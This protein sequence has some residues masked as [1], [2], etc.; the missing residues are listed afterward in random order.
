MELTEPA[1]PGRFV[2][3]DTREGWVSAWAH[4]ID[5]ATEPGAHHVVLDVSGLRPYAA[6][7]KRFGGKASGPAPF[8]AA[9]LA[10]ADVVSGAV[11]RRLSGLE[12]MLA[13]HEIAAAVVAGGTRRSARLALMHW[14][15]QE[16]FDF[17]SCKADHMSHWSAN[18]SV[19]IDA[20]FRSALRSGDEHAKAVFGAVTTGMA[21]NGEPGF[22]DTA[23]A[24][25][26][27]PKPLRSVNPCLAGG[28]RLLTRDG[29]VPIRDLAGK[30]FE[31]WNGQEWAQSKAWSTG[32]KPVYEAR[33]T[34]GASIKATADHILAT[35]DG[36]APVAEL[37]GR[38]AVVMRAPGDNEDSS[39]RV[40]SVAYVG[41]EEVFDFS[42]PLTHWGWANG[43]KV[44]NSGEAFLA[45]DNGNDGA[46][47]SCNLGQVDLDAFG[48]DMEGAIE[49]VELMARFLYRSTLNPHP[50]EPARR[51]EAV[52]RR[53][54]VGVM[55]VQGWAAAHG[56]KLSELPDSQE[57]LGK[58]TE[59]RLAARRSADT[60][61]D[62]LGTPRPVKVTAVAPTGTI[63]NL[64][65]T[66]PGPH[67]VFARYFLRRVR[68]TEH[69]AA[70]RRLAGEGYDVVDDIYA[71]A[72]KVVAFPMRDSVLDRHP[73]ELIEQADEIPV[74][75]FLDI[76]VA[77]QET[78]CGGTDGQAVSATAQVPAGTSPDDL[79]R[80]IASRLG[81]LK[82]I[83]VFPDVSRPLPPLEAVSKER[84]EELSR[85][86]GREAVGDSSTGCV[87]GACPVR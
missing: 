80:A 24:S 23:L 40:V 78:F 31:I 18:I 51:I 48:A 56:Y 70:W 21:C 57:L 1:V 77:V 63:S 82:G 67:P 55:G 3:D 19:E 74:E 5:L 30:S 79:A 8:A 75:R 53:I 58:L 20:E 66:T 60:L 61:A 13:D 15:D 26:T 49:A 9:A 84:Y 22:I 34:N 81:R 32:V 73:S 47:E 72:T 44:H 17:I 10:I 43:F 76:V 38:D 2:V 86:V 35:T 33:L 27:E 11:G 29:L 39:S 7:L 25:E 4:I 14:A 54:G 52:N 71:A 62:Q 85:M 87:G 64:R 83:T 41:E 6:P 28:T 59:L 16:I 46:G 69:D 45:T 36:E 37:L 68:F 50:D 65:G 42:E 12:T